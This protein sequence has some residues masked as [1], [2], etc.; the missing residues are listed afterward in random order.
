MHGT[1][2]VPAREFD[3][4]HVLSDVKPNHRIGTMVMALHVLIIDEAFMLDKHVLM[5]LDRAFRVR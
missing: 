2:R 3:E 5:A 4:Q 1:F